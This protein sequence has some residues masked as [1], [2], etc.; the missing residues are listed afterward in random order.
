MAQILQFRHRPKMRPAPPRKKRHGVYL[1][2][3][4]WVALVAG[5]ALLNPEFPSKELGISEIA[6]VRLAISQRFDFCSWS[7]QSYCVIDGDTIRYA[8]TKIRIEDIDTPE[9]HDYKCDSELDRGLRAKSR[10]LELI[11]AGPFEIVYSGGRDED[12]C[13]RKLRRIV[14][15]GLSLGELLVD[16]GLARRYAGGRRSWCL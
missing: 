5:I 8:G 11:N 7:S 15:N 2:V 1:S 14:R 16:E 12:H 4:V 9:I 13:G 10:L 6:P 3:P